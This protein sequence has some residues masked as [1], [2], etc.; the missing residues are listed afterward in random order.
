[1]KYS[2]NLSY[3][4][5]VLCALAVVNAVTGADMGAPLQSHVAN[6][7]PRW[8]NVTPVPED[9]SDEFV[10]DL[11]ELAK[12]T[13]VDSVAYCCTLVPEGNPPTDKAAIYAKRIRALRERLRAIS[14]IRQGVLFQATMGHGWKPNSTTPWQKVIGG[15]WGA[16]PD[17]PLY[18]FCPLGSEFLAYIAQAAKTLAAEKPD[19]FMVDD[20]VRL[21]T[22]VDG[23]YCPR[24]LAEFARRTGKVRTREEVMADCRDDP[25]LAAEW[26]RLRYD[27]IALLLKTIRDQFPPKVSGMFCCCTHDAHHA[28]RLA[29]ILAAPGQRPSVRLNNSWYCNHSMIEMPRILSLTAREIADIGEGVDILDE[30]DTCPQNRYSTS[31]TRMIDHAVMATFEGCVGGKMWITRLSNA[32]ETRSGAYYRTLL[33]RQKGFLETVSALGVARTGV[34]IPLP[35]NRPLGWPISYSPVDWGSSFFGYMGIPYRTARP[36]KGDVVALSAFDLRYFSD[37]ELTNLLSGAVL[38]DGAAAIGLTKRGFGGLIG[39]E[40]KDWTGATISAEDFGDESLKGTILE[41][42]DLTKRAAGAEELSRYLHASSG[43]ASADEYLAP[44][45]VRFRNARGGTVVTVAAKLV[46]RP[47]DLRN[48][49]YFNETRKRQMIKV[50]RLL[51]GGR[52]PGGLL[53]AGDAPAVCLNGIARDGSRVFVIDGIGADTIERPEMVFEDGVPQSVERLDDAGVWRPVGFRVERGEVRLD[54]PVES[55]RP[56]VFRRE[57]PVSGEMRRPC[58]THAG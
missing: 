11:A 24:H 36:A 44:G 12:S 19:F 2:K 55:F 37:A 22:G 23:C 6:C 46:Q 38:L 4:F 26:D 9:V 1:M 58:G 3:S 35:E 34:V 47:D 16:P 42:A 41:A 15:K 51:A 33:K 43:L 27:S 39:V 20:D 5:A 29:R 21:I 45:S 54:S 18:K 50:V 13:V 49:W 17:N 28:G 25:A 32:H 7:A 52:L 53:Y 31:A 8:V 48:F 30:I 40:A 14:P 57:M 56:G 10:A